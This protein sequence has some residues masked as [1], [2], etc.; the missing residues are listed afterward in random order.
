MDDLTLAVLAA[1]D[2]EGAIEQHLV[3]GWI[4][5]S[6]E[7]GTD[8]LLYRLTDEA[9]ERIEPRL[10]G[11]ETCALIQ[12]YLLRCI[13]DHP[14]NDKILSSFE[15]AETL[16]IWFGHLAAM[17]TP[18]TDE[19][20][21]RAAFAVTDLFLT[22]DDYARNVIETG[23]LEHLL[24]QKELRHWFEYWTR[25]ERLRDAW[26]AALAW[27]EAHPDFKA[28]MRRELMWRTRDRAL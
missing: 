2:S 23:F 7:I 16:E 3:R 26:T 8:A 28:G 24:E 11:A 18:E 10:E 14:R 1:L 5:Q 21:R 9:W 6:Q 13:R 22:G 17:A 25:D 15:A 4:E 20:L 27:G 12:R 19:I